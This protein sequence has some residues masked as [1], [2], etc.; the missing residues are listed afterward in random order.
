[1]RFVIVL[2]SILFATQAYADCLEDPRVCDNSQICTY[3]ANKSK[4]GYIWDTAWWPMHVREA[5]RRGLTCKVSPPKPRYKKIQSIYDAFT[6][7]DLESRKEVQSQLKAEGLY[8]SGIDGLYGKRTQT[9]IA[10]YIQ[11]KL[12]ASEIN[13][14]NVQNTL[15]SILAITEVKELTEKNNDTKNN[16]SDEDTARANEISPELVEKRHKPITEQLMAD[17]MAEGDFQSAILAAKIL[18]PQGNSAAQFVLGNAYAEGIGVLQQFKLAHMWLN[19]ASLNGSSEAVE[20]RNELQKKM[21][22]ET[23]MEAQELA[24]KCIQ[25]EYKNCGNSPAANTTKFVKQD[26]A[27]PV[28]ADEVKQTFLSSSSL[29]RK[30]IQYALKDLGLYASSID[31]MWGAG[32]ERGIQNYIKLSDQEF[33]TAKELVESLL[34]KVDV[35]SSFSVSQPSKTSPS[36]KVASKPINQ[37]PKFREPSGWRSFANVSHSFAQADAICRPQARNAGRGVTAAPKLGAIITN[38]NAFGN[39]VNCTTDQLGGRSFNDVI[40]SL[41]AERNAYNGCMAQYGWQRTKRQ[42][43]FGR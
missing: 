16:A 34:A 19:I 18:A 33:T 17:R 12:N 5:K 4:Y 21:T 41:G 3:A 35:P 25:S 26:E 14:T 22:P 13:D 37:K 1:M 27:E 20:T 32:T 10:D 28:Q 7:L 23:V 6:A 2:F 36:P 9:A 24:I 15:T 8:K 43:L 42:G 11:Q 31:A 38:C 39:S 40:A 30:Q 29:R